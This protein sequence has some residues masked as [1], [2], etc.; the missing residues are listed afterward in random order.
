MKRSEDNKL[1]LQ[2]R[3]RV[4]QTKEDAR[5]KGKEDAGQ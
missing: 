4:N 3:L 5:G 2:G 1:Y